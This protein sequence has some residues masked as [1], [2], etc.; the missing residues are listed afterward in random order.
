MVKENNLIKR[1]LTIASA[2]A[3][4]F[5][6]AMSSG[7]PANAGTLL[8][9]TK[10]SHLSDYGGDNTDVCVMVTYEKGFNRDPNGNPQGFS[11]GE[12]ETWCNLTPAWNWESDM[13]VNGHGLTIKN[14]D[15]DKVKWSV[16]EDSNMS[17]GT[18]HCHHYYQPVLY[19][20]KAHQ[21]RI[22]FWFTDRI[23]GE[24]DYDNGVSITLSQ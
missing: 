17:T 19:M 20:G 13:A 3:L 1:L 12:V 16:G 10:C 4:V 9:T 15:I 11:I 8:H 22:N 14:W 18:N 6:L 2:L 24:S 21:A 23:D 7:N 5:G